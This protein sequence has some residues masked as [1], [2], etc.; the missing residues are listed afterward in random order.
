MSSAP[1]SPHPAEFTAVRKQLF[2]NSGLL[3]ISR[4]L[5]MGTSL[6][7]VPVVLS[8]LGL[9]G[10]GGWEA[11]MAIA[12]LVTVFQT[13]VN[14]TLVW[15]MSAAYGNGDAAGIRRLMGEGIAVV[16]GMFALITPLV[17]ATRYQ[18]VGLSNIPPLYRDAAVWV[19][20]ILVSQTTLGAAGETFAAVLIAH[21]RAGITTLIQT[22]ALMANS[23]FVIVGLLHGW[24]VWSL[25]LGNT[26]GVVAA[27]AV[28]IWRL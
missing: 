26:V 7:T 9:G 6:V 12:A 27:I 20:P 16:L 3:G 28:S 5:S 17:W 22:T 21:Q 25:L 4:L 18:L 15:K 1:V 24:Q 19:I 2:V 13:T 11:M 23:G 8:R 10:Y 14:G